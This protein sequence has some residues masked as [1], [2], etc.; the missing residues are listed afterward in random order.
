MQVFSC[1]ICAL[2]LT[3]SV[4]AQCTFDISASINDLETVNLQINVE[5]LINDDMSGAQAICAVQLHF[6]HSYLG[7]VTIDLTSPAGQTVQLVGVVTDQIN[8]TNLTTWDVRFLQCGFPASP[9]PGFTALWNN[10]QAWQVFTTYTGSYY[11]SQGCLEDFNIGS[12]NGIW[13]LSITDHDAPQTGTLLGVTLIFC[14]DAGLECN[15]CGVD[16]GAFVQ[17]MVSICDGTEITVEPDY[18]DTIPDP[19]LYGY[20]FLLTEDN[21]NHIFTEQLS[22]STLSS[23]TYTIC[24]IS[25]SRADSSSLFAQ[26]DTMTFDEI[27]SAYANDQFAQCTDITETCMLLEISSVIDT[28]FLDQRICSG[29]SVSI[30]GQQFSTTGT[31]IVTI[32]VPGACDSVVVLELEVTLVDAR[33]FQEDTISCFNGVTTLDGSISIAG[34]GASYVWST[35]NGN[36]ISPA[37]QAVITIDGSGAYLLRVSDQGCFDELLFLAIG[38]ESIPFIAVDGGVI[39]CNS[40]EFTFNTIVFPTNV[41][42]EWSGPNGFVSDLLNPTVMSPGNYLL[43]V[44]DPDGCTASTL[45]E[46]ILDTATIAPAIV[47]SIDCFNDQTVVSGTP[48]NLEYLYS[49]TGPNGF[50]NQTR[51]FLTSEPGTYCATLTPP[52][53]CPGTTC[54]DILAEYSIPDVLVVAS[55]DSIHCGD[56]VNLSMS[57]SIVGVSYAWYGPAGYFSAS[58]TIDVF[59]SGVYIAVVT[60]PNGCTN[61]DTAV[62]FPGSDVFDAVTF[63]DTITCVVDTALIGVVTFEPGAIYAWSGPGLVDTFSAFVHVV[64]PGIYQVVVTV[65]TCDRI[66]TIRVSEDFSQANFRA[67]TDTITCS[68]PVAELTILISSPYE[69]IHWQFPDGSVSMDSVLYTMQSGIHTLSVSSANGCVGFR[70]VFVAIDTFPPTLFLDSE[71]LGCDSVQIQTVTVNSL[72]AFD[73]SGPGGFNSQNLNPYVRIGGNYIFRATADNGCVATKIHFVDTDTTS[74]V[75]QINGEE[76]DCLDSSAVLTIVSSDTAVF[77]SWYSAGIQISDSVSVLVMQPGQYVGALLGANGCSSFDTIEVLPPIFPKSFTQTDTITCVNVAIL[78]ATSDMPDALLYWEDAVG[79]TGFGGQ[80]STTQA[81]AVILETIGSNGCTSDTTVIVG[82]D[83]LAPVAIAISNEMVL[84]NVQTITLDA[85][86]SVGQISNYLWTTLDGIIESGGN[87]ATPIITGEGTYIVVVTD[88]SNGCTDSDTIHVVEGQSVLG[89]IHLTTISECE[90]NGNGS[91]SIDSVPGAATLLSYTI[92]DEAGG[93]VFDGLT[94]GEYH[95]V[96]IDSFGCST[97]TIINI[98]NTSSTHS[99]SLGVDKDILIGDSVLLDAIVD[100]DP[101]EIMSVHWGQ[102][103]DCDTCLAN[104]VTPLHT[105]TYQIFLEDIFGC[106]ASD[107]VTVFVAEQPKFYIANVFSPNGD[108]VNDELTIAAHPGIARILEFSVYDRWGNVVFQAK[109]FPGSDNSVSW[110]GTFGGKELNPAV[111]VYILTVE[112]LTGRVETNHGTVTIVK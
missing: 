12:A 92:D 88:E 98:S 85:S 48:G 25:Y 36:I 62:I 59:E 13:Q 11:P 45:V 19:L 97:D 81:G 83:T 89:I 96:V 5:N 21:V 30:G 27:Q 37:D 3:S 94:N 24:G 29:S 4:K 71:L 100:L 17:T 106:I 93:P 52:N 38:D 104:F 14:D 76:L 42:P 50:I 40:P 63:G 43:L 111:F 68:E 1:C 8:P 56:Q 75:F 77:Y 103:V 2:M 9:D 67:F 91:I 16:A 95:I 61:S 53:G 35:Q 82:S 20:V 55:S 79:M 101:S 51:Q 87:T 32:D 72:V 70:Q 47:T 41:I 110:D 57:S 44:T 7:D 66:F 34:P 6:R 28:T 15:V 54:I 49:W 80:F 23:G 46:I 99:I 73:W 109:N 22:T 69:E 60:S 18:P 31:H 64:V 26:L 102:P 108:N 107:L 78:Y 65:G 86:G 84:C 10:N 105:A 33:A 90:G 58:P 39:D 112:L 74:P